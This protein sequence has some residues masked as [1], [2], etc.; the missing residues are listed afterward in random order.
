MEQ[1]CLRI[2]GFSTRP[3]EKEL[4]R[5][6][7][8]LMKKYHP[9][10]TGGET[11]P[12]YTRVDTAYQYL[13]GK[14]NYQQAEAIL[15]PDRK[16]QRATSYRNTYE[17]AAGQTSFEEE[18]FR[19]FYQQHADEFDENGYYRQR[20]YTYD[21]SFL[22][23][24]PLILLFIFII[25]MVLLFSFVRFLFTPVGLVCLACYLIWRL[26]LRRNG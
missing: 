3:S 5:A 16:N 14:M 18:F 10:V 7:K 23:Y 4:K 15:F 1:E 13:T 24:V 21:T 22:K 19:N 2:L 12:E 6:Y 25:I 9:D 20:Y 11:S 8:K 26:F 17:S